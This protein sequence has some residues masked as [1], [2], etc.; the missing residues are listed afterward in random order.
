MYVYIKSS[1]VHFNYLTISAVDYTSMKLGG[2]KKEDL[3]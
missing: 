3:A 1:P 2:G